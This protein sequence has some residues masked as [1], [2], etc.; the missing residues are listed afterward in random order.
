MSS[1]YITTD[2][3]KCNLGEDFY[4]KGSVKRG[5]LPKFKYKVVIGSENEETEICSGI[6]SD[7]FD[8]DG[9]C[10]NLGADFT[11]HAY[12]YGDG[13]MCYIKATG[14][15]NTTLGNSETVEY[16]A[17]INLK[18]DLLPDY[19]ISFDLNNG[20]CTD[21]GNYAVKGISKVTA[22]IEVNNLK[23]GEK[24]KSVMFSGGVFNQTESGE[25]LTEASCEVNPIKTAGDVYAFVSV[26]NSLG[27][28][29]SKSAFINVLDY[30]EPSLVFD[31]KPCRK[32]DSGTV[33][34]KVNDGNKNAWH[35]LVFAGS[36]KPCEMKA[37]NTQ[38]CRIQEIAK[39]A[40]VKRIGDSKSANIDLIIDKS[41]GDDGSLGFSY[42]GKPDFG[43]DDDGNAEIGLQVFKA[44]ELTIKCV[45][46]SKRTHELKYRIKTLGTAFHLLKGGKGAW[47]GAFSEKDNVL[48][49]EWKIHGKQDIEADGALIGSELKLGA[50]SIT[51]FGSGATQAAK[52]NH[53][54]GF[55]NDK[56]Q[57]C[58]NEGNPI[59]KKLI[60]ITDENGYIVGV[61]TLTSDDILIAKDSAMKASAAIG[62]SGSVGTAD[63]GFCFADH[64]HPYSDA[65]KNDEEFKKLQ[66]SAN[67]LVALMNDIK[68]I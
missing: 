18:G 59:K 17:Y 41:T 14:T 3:L 27:Y 37:D 15:R 4:I 56:G 2:K 33:I 24:I 28:Q 45:D 8:G 25:S 12:P 23:F 20:N 13:K 58:D 67:D 66:N 50:G 30:R 55:I 49:S 61:E 60:L 54:H 32:D 53:F 44:Y 48:G 7:A 31:T 46:S 52:G 65:W 10:V 51:G 21:F 40:T 36:V 62:A 38:I 16:V 5:V 64:I 6:E 43:L 1:G 19:S 22:K 68:N 63:A 9:I 29:T 42:I 57:L 35:N 11:Q 34:D 26:T 39:E 47:F